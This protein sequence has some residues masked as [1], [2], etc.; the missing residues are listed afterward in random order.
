MSFQPQK[1]FISY[2]PMIASCGQN[3]I[4]LTSFVSL[5]CQ[6]L[7][8]PQEQVLLSCMCLYFTHTDRQD[9]G[10][11]CRWIHT[12]TSNRHAVSEQF[13]GNQHANE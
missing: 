12:I 6:R 13:S 9:S 8:T 2:L 5:L 3:I 10:K 11:T 4:Q 7:H 1:V